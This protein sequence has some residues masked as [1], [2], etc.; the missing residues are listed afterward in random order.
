MTNWAQI[1]RALLCDEL[2]DVGPD[3]PTLCGSWTATDLAA[4]LVLRERR[5]VAAA[6]IVVR[7]PA[8]AR[9]T[10][11]VQQRLAGQPWGELVDTL[12]SGPPRWSPTSI[13]G[14]DALANTIEFFV[15]HEDVRR[16]RPDWQPRALDAGFE[17]ALAKALGRMK[18]L[19]R[20]SP[21][22]VSF[23]AP[24]GTVLLARSG[25]T[26]VTVTGPVGELVLYAFGRQ[27]VARVTLDGDADAAERLQHAGLGV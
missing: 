24:D 21:V 17:A 2:E 12:R 20:N 26:P 22:G 14:L 27:S 8:M 7:L 25:P 3:A 16:A 11:K 6:G 5:P 9:Y 19:V 10:E 1:E 4:H 15:H 18:L 23:V 13:D